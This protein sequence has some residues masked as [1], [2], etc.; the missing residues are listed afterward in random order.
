MEIALQVGDM[1]GL[2]RHAHNLKGLSANFSANAISSLAAE[3]EQQTKQ[4]NITNA[5]ALID[6]INAES[7]RLVKYYNENLL[8]Q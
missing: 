1:K 7:Q 8:N 3:L 5:A 2:N 4:E 6:K